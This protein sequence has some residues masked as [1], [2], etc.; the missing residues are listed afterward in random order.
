MATQITIR[1]RQYTVRSDEPSEDLHAVAKYVDGKMG[2]LASRSSTFDD[3]TVAMLAALHPL[4]VILSAIFLAGIYVGADS[5]SR[6]VDIPNYIADV[7]V[8]TSVLAV[9]VSLMLTQYR[10]RFR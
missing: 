6:S 8:A 9:L 4:G 7:M 3:Y 1:G 5:M 10:I 2:E